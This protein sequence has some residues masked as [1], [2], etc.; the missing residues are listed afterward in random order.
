[1]TAIDLFA[2]LGGWTLG[3]EWA[4]LRVVWAGNHWRATVDIHAAN[5]PHTVHACQ[6]LAQADWHSIPRHDVT[7]ASPACQGHAHARGI[8]RPHHDA[9][10]STAWAVVECCEVHRPAVCVV[11]NV[12]EF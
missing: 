7:L 11:E 9:A 4:G 10:R 6:D 8:D 5:H 2:G 3:A 1:M 12:T